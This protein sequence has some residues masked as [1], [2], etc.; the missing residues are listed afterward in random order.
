MGEKNL[1]LPLFESKA[2]RGRK[3]YKL[4]AS[5][6]FVGI[7][8]IW[9]YRLINMPRRG[10]SGRLAWIVMFL[11]ELCFGFY[12]IITQSARW[13]VIYH[14]PFKN[15]L[16]LRYEEKL[17]SVDIF[18]CT[19]D[20][21]MEPP[22]M[23]INTVLSV[24]SFNYPPEK[25]CVY[26]SDDGA[27]EYTFYALFEASQFSRYW[28]PFCKRFNVEP[29]SPAAYFEHDAC[30]LEDKVFAQ[31]WFNTKKLYEDMT[32]RIETT[33]E[34]GSI[35][36]E[37]KAQHKG[38][39]E[40]N[41]KVTKQD[42]Q[43]IVQ[44]LIDGRNHNMTDMDG[45]RLP[46]LIRV[47][48]QISNAP[49][50]LNLD[51]DMYSNDPD[52]IR[53]ALCFFMDENQGKEI[54]YVQYPQRY[55]NV[56]KNDIYG[57]VARVTHE[58]A[59]KVVA[60]VAMKRGLEWGKQ[61]GLMYGCPVEDIITG[62]AIQCRGWRSKMVEGM[63]RIFIS[64]YCPF[65]YGHGKIKLGAQT[66]YCIYLLWGPISV[67]TL[68]YVLFPSLCPL[69]G[70]PISETFLF[71][72]VFTTCNVTNLSSLWLL[73][74]AYV[75]TAKFAYS[76]V[77]TIRMWMIRRITAYFFAF[78]DAVTKQLGFSETTF[79]LTTKVVDDNVQRRYEQEI[80]EFGNSSAMFTITATLALPNSISFIWGIK[81]LVVALG[82]E[83][84]VLQVI[85]C[86]LIVLV[87]VP[88][89]EALFFRKG[90]KGSFPSA[91]LVSV[92]HPSINS[93]SITYLLDCNRTPKWVK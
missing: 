79:A 92:R 44:I 34:S 45:N 51:C 20:P 40:W 18:V 77:E 55:N 29:R 15:T 48:S 23:V 16:S 75:F 63:F 53:E 93:M 49:I 5:T 35:P 59:S 31:E 46:T 86:G 54:A 2:A 1:H 39:S 8:L 38:F 27:S 76:L 64:K 57:N 6:M 28:I 71:T 72:F 83:N 65:I 14:Y 43:S 90:D 66:G 24:M 58:E 70:I 91:I 82:A 84:I 47:S 10:E 56:T 73:P 60:T 22:T 61:M 11:A 42:H 88:V 50:I 41:S 52:A 85:L 26:L 69:H 80:M 68:T 81:K 3:M 21:I 4:F 7:C 33:I 78:I 13:H 89:Y 62:L 9:L 32:I 17:P 67:P 37:I 19:A 30:N 74:F 12:W 36:N 25:L 87:N